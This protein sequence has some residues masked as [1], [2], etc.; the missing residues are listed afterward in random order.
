MRIFDKRLYAEIEQAFVHPGFDFIPSENGGGRIIND[1]ALIK[2]K[3]PLKFSSTIQPACLGI[4][5]QELYDGIL[6][7][8]GWGST[9]DVTIDPQNG[10]SSDVV[11][12]RYLKEADTEDHSATMEICEDNQQNVCVENT[13]TKDTACKGGFSER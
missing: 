10:Q 11:I 8:S 12:S 3:S 4:E 6:K 7:M 5:H 2:L 1:I 13:K 9:V